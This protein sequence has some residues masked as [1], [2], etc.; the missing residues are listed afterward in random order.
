VP[1]IEILINEYIRIWG[2]WKG[3]SAEQKVAL[4]IRCVRCMAQEHCM[5]MSEKCCC[6]LA[7]H[8]ILAVKWRSCYIRKKS[9]RLVVV[10]EECTPIQRSE[11][12]NYLRKHSMK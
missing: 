8:R 9:H 7:K 11:R 4:K 6:L 12:S 5:E 3:Q 2:W 1:G 10:A